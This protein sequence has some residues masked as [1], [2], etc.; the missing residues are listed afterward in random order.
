MMTT[1]ATITATAGITTI[2]VITIITTAIR[3]TRDPFPW[4][5]MGWALLLVAFAVAA[6]S[7]VQVRSVKPR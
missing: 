1:A 7:L 2:M 4:R 6:A 5:R 3:K